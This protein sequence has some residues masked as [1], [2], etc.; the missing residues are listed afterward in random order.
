M[1]SG[2]SLLYLAGA[3]ALAG[4]AGLWAWRR[5]RVSPAE[6]ERRRRVNVGHQGRMADGTATDAHDGVLYYSYSV[7][8]VQY[9]TSQDIGTLLGRLPAEPAMLMGTVTVKYLS[10]NPANSIVISEEWSGFRQR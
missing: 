6:K 10:K 5:R 9:V 2:A 7:R 4:A 3:G 8:G 1:N